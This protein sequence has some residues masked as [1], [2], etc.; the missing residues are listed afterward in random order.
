[1][2]GELPD[3]AS[4]SAESARLFAQHR[5]A[6]VGAAYRLLGSLS[7]AEDVAQETWLRWAEV[8]LREVTNPRA[9]LVRIGTR[10]ALNRLRQLSR[11]RESYVG[12]WLPEPVDD[13]SRVGADATLEVAESVSLAMLVLLETL[14]PAERAAFILT[15]SSMF[16][17]TKWRARWIVTPLQYA[18]SFIGRAAGCGSRLLENRSTPTPIDALPSSF[19][20]LFR[21]DPSQTS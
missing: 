11:Q 4:D 8:P 19:F 15:T 18:S 20:V 17:T 5:S 12:P 3:V 6:V 13:L 14:T 10:L 1:M 21:T 9:Y 7:D 16:P 2:N